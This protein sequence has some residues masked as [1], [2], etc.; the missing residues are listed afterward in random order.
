MFGIAFDNTSRVGIVTEND[1]TKNAKIHLIRTDGNNS[2]QLPT[3]RTS[4]SNSSIGTTKSSPTDNSSAMK[5]V[6]TYYKTL[7]PTQAIYYD[8]DK[9]PDPQR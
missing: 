3:Q 7:T 9:F 1:P 6:R 5:P 8:G 2:F 4:S